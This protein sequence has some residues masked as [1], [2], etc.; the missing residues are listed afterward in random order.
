MNIQLRGISLV[1]I[2][3]AG[4]APA[5]EISF[6]DQSSQYG[7]LHQHMRG[8]RQFAMGG[9]AAWLDFDQDGDEDLLA[10]NSDG[11]HIL[12]RNDGNTFVDVTLNSGLSIRVTDTNFGVSV[13]DYNQDGL[14]DIFCANIGP[15]QLFT[16][17]GGG[18]FV[19]DAAALGLQDARWAISASW[20]DFDRDGDLDLYVGN[21]IASLSFPYQSGAA[22]LLYV[23]VGT[24]QNP[25]FQEQAL[26]LGVANV[27]VFG[28]PVPGFP[29]FPSRE[30][31][32]AAGCTLSVCTLDFDEDG[33]QDLLVGNDFGEWVIPDKLYRNDTPMGGALVFTDVSVA[34]GFGSHGHYN[35]GINGS[36]YDLDGDWDFYLSNLGPNF[37]FQNN[38]G[39]FSDV[40][41][42][43]G[44]V[45]GQ[46][47]AGT[48]LLTSW[49]TIWSDF[50]NDLYEDILVVNGYIPAASFIANDKSATNHVFAN[51]K[52][53]TFQRVDP[54]QSG[55]DDM[56]VGRG[57]AAS[58][59]NGD[60]WMDFYMMNN[61]V[62][63]TDPAERCR[64]FI[65][66]GSTQNPGRKA[67]Q[68]RLFGWKSNKEGLG[69]RLLA[70]VGGKT[71]RAARSW[72]IRSTPPVAPVRCTLAPVWPTASPSSP[73][74]GLPGCTRNCTAFPAV[75]PGPCMNLGSPWKPCPPGMKAARR[76]C[77]SPSSSPTTPAIY[78]TLRCTCCSTLARTVR[79]P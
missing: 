13:A 49:G 62:F 16:N 50:N 35:M 3:L 61:G 69:A 58:D 24:A 29:Q 17:L 54:V 10:T 46:N 12:Y 47:D 56:G 4:M 37:L 1:A 25:Q 40:A 5:Q 32:A 60:G 8:S 7:V 53:G 66:Q 48:L 72:R 2:A 23:N 20:A 15:N 75:N 34:T 22:N 51:Q 59:V 38:G 44:C 42:T 55:M 70:E 19:D 9:G 30:G 21:Y 63:P 52:N 67:C 79:W 73:P 65:N 31:E 36:D 39:V 28:P 68:L 26:A 45:D 27:G 11:M 43:A 57:V 18:K 41:A 76:N 6:Q 14:P 77:A 33:D 78:K 74:T 64:L 71:L